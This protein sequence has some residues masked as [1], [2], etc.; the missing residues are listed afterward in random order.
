MWLYIPHD[1]ELA[2][3]PD[4][5]ESTSD[6]GSRWATRIRRYCTAR[7]KRMSP[8][9]WSQRCRRAS[10]IALLSGPSLRACRR[11]ALLRSWTSTLRASLCTAG[12]PAS[13]SA[14][15]GS[16]KASTMKDGSGPPF[17]ALHER[18]RWDG[19]SW[20]T[21]GG[22]FPLEAD[23][24]T[25][26][27]T[28]PKAGGLRNGTC[29]QRRSS[30]RLISGNESFS[31]QSP[32]TVDA[33]GRK[34]QRSGQTEYQCL[35]GQVESEYP[36]HMKRLEGESDNEYWER[37]NKLD[38]MRAP[39]TAPDAPQKNSNTK[40]GPKN[41]QEALNWP[42]A[43]M[44]D[45][46]NGSGRHERGNPTLAGAVTGRPVLEYGSNHGSSL[47]RWPTPR[48]RR[49]LNPAWVEQLMGLPEDWTRVYGRIGFGLAEMESYL[50]KWRSLLWSFFGD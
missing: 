2:S 35:P 46:I 50:S 15:P 30:A 7:G 27:P 45:A 41:F 38:R 25:F 39:C 22:L 23:W 28:S 43:T 32:N 8:R 16:G 26:W 37:M 20:R 42:T 36:E 13:L 9:S 5:A 33:T 3:A 17:G 44:A 4:M 11:A 1:S 48:T 12:Y 10:W 29:F 18:L 31:W 40:N 21:C 19:S 24:S 34:Y 47:G 6:S 14:P 49:K